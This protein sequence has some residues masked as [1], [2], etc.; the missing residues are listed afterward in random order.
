M[1]IKNIL[2]CTI[3]S[4]KKWTADIKTGIYRRTDSVLQKIFVPGAAVSDVFM[5]RRHN[6]TSFQKATQR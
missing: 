4:Y 2:L 3:T 6:E 1:N 5:N